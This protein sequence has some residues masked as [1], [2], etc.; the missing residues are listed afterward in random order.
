VQGVT[1]H[2][3]AQRERSP[4]ALQR[5]RSREAW[6]VRLRG[7]KQRRGLILILYSPASLPGFPPLPQ[8]GDLS[9][10]RFPHLALSSSYDAH[11]H[12]YT[13][14]EPFFRGAPSVRVPHLPS[15]FDEEGTRMS[16]D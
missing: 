2:G 4:H 5:L 7:S 12:S 3:A 14:K 8:R 9:C 6:T 16:A 13:V 1:I 11:L 10:F 15:L